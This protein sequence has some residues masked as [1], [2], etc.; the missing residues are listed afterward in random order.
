MKNLSSTPLTKD[1]ERLLA[2]GPKFV[3]KPRQP[4]VGEYIVAVEQPCSELGQ[5]ETDELRVEVKKAL[6]KTQNTPRVQ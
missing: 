6:K 1:Q 2:Q 3:I 5:G 4:P